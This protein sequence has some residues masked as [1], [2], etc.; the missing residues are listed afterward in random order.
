MTIS[1]TL[2]SC[3]CKSS[4]IYLSVH[5]FGRAGVTDVPIFTSK[6]RRSGGRPHNM[7]ALDWQSFLFECVP[8][9]VGSLV[10]DFNFTI[11]QQST[12]VLQHHVTRL[13]IIITAH[14]LQDTRHNTWTRKHQR[15]D[16]VLSSSSSS[17]SS[18]DAKRSAKA[19]RR[20]DC[21][22]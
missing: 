11:E 12:V 7:S 10:F 22:P 6:G 4:G 17:S 20:C 5:R 18:S 15:L 3:H 21:S 9:C 8:L 19:S 14:Q 1:M 16:H 2:S 13:Q